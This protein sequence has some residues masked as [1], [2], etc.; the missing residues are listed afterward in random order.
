MEELHRLHKDVPFGW[1]V[2]LQDV[3]A[4][5]RQASA[6]LPRRRTLARIG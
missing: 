2:W 4:R 5:R 6:P 3:L 1:L